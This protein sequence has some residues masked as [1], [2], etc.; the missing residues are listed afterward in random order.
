MAREKV[1]PI[2]PDE[3]RTLK[4]LVYDLSEMGAKQALW[5]MIQ[6]LSLKTSIT[7]AQFKEVLDDAAKY[8]QTKKQS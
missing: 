5:G 6:I 1:F 7:Q 2:Y 4:A 3:A 8:C